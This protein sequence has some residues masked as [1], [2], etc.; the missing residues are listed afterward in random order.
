[1]KYAPIMPPTWL[2]KSCNKDNS[3]LVFTFDDSSKAQQFLDAGIFLCLGNWM[4]TS[5]YEEKKRAFYC[6]SCGSMAHCTK[7]CTDPCC[8]KC[9]S[10]EHLAPDHPND[11]PI[12]CVNCSQ[13][14]LYNDHSCYIYKKKMNIPADPPSLSFTIKPP[15]KILLTLS[16]HA[17]KLKIFESIDESKRTYVKKKL[18][19]FHLWDDNYDIDKFTNLLNSYWPT[20]AQT[21]TAMTDAMD[22]DPIVVPNHSSQWIVHLPIPLFYP[23]TTNRAIIILIFSVWM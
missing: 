18:D 13:D 5:A 15:P 16:L 23:R 10:R 21:L 22:E 20:G 6:A 3:T 2:V 12:K 8:L 9:G 14:H 7:D 11:S 19:R 17:Q 4:T 1:L